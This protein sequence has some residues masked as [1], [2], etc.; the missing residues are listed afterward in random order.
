MNSQ[1]VAVMVGSCGNNEGA[2]IASVP[3]TRSLSSWSHES[4]RRVGSVM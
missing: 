2:V 4:G 1:E 3:N